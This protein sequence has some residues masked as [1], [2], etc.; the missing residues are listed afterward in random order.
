MVFKNALIYPGSLLEVMYLNPF[1]QI[2][3]F[4]PKKAI[5]AMDTMIYSFSWEPFW[6]IIIAELL[7]RIGQEDVNME[8]FVMN[9]DPLYNAISGKNWLG[10]IKAMASPFHKKIEISLS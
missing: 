10:K 2:W 1:N 4:I 8:F 5:R 7:I 3:P 6:P 9:I